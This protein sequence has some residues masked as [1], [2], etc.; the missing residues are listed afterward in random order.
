MASSS[1]WMSASRAPLASASCID[2]STA[3][4]ISAGSDGEMSQMPIPVARSA[5]AAPSSRRRSTM[6]ASAPLGSSRTRPSIDQTMNT[7]DRS[8]VEIPLS[9]NHRVNNTYIGANS[10]MNDRRYSRFLSPSSTTPQ[11][12]GTCRLSKLAAGLAAFVT[13]WID[14]GWKIWRTSR[15]LLLPHQRPSVNEAAVID[16]RCALGSTPS[17]VFAAM[18]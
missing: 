3:P 6:S 9:L 2:Q 17:V 15:L 11:S 7:I 10:S 1:S 13:R 5:S 4:A 14:P 12:Y 8:A 16:S 18:R